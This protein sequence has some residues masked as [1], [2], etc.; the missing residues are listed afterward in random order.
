MRRGQVEFVAL[1]G[2]VLVAL[3][4]IAIAYQD[5]LPSI[6][7]A[8]LSSDEQLVH[9]SVNG[10]LADG[11]IHVVDEMERHGGYLS[12][13]QLGN[14]DGTIPAFTTYLGDGVPYWQVCDT[15]LAPSMNQ[16][17][18][19]F[20][21]ALKKYLTENMN[22]NPL[23]GK[24]VTFDL[25]K[26]SIEI[27]IFDSRVEATATIPTKIKGTTANPV[28]QAMTPTSLGRI[29]SFA[30]DVATSFANTRQFDHNTITSLYLVKDA[31]DGFSRIPV[32]GMIYECG[33]GFTRSP[34]DLGEALSDV[35]EYVL[36]NTYW[37]V[38]IPKEDDKQM[39]FDITTVNGVSY[40]DLTIQQ[41]LPDGLDFTA[42][43]PMVAYANKQLLNY[44][45]LAI[46]GLALPIC[47]S[48][49]LFAPSF[50]YPYIIEVEDE[51]TGNAFRFAGFVS[52]EEMK[53][54]S[55]DSATPLDVSAHCPD[56]LCTGTVRVRD[57][58]GTPVPGAA[59]IYG[60]CFSGMTDTNGVLTGPVAC[61]GS[62]TLH[63]YEPDHNVLSQTV[64]TAELVNGYDVTIGVNVPHTMSFR[65][66]TVATGTPYTTCTS[67]VPDGPVSVKLTA[68]ETIHSFLNTD[69]S[70]CYDNPTP[71]CAACKVAVAEN[72]DAAVTDPTCTD[73]VNSCIEYASS[74]TVPSSLHLVP[75]IGGSPLDTLVS[76]TYTVEGNFLSAESPFGLEP[77]SGFQITGAVPTTPDP[78]AV[79]LPVP[80]GT[81]T[82]SKQQATMD[83][84]NSCG[85]DT[86]RVGGPYASTIYHFNQVCTC[87]DLQA[88]ATMLQG[89]GCLTAQQVAGAFASTCSPENVKAMISSSCDAAIT[90]AC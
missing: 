28:Y 77:V 20:A 45:P 34:E 54:A 50:T 87:S 55:C 18:T 64:A 62:D 74:I 53:V 68:G 56:L 8:A 17:K 30:Q 71:T 80:G 76:G 79:S 7:P 29:I 41:R 81:T 35:V 58:E 66:V 12:L 15:N 61:T 26:L 2:I 57:N 78:L 31:D 72:G 88:I 38:D 89:T 37:F 44:P 1:V 33:T 49:F 63:V 51:F 32:G 90:G 22:I 6:G 11:I 14:E 67:V 16:I 83:L 69:L 43:A 70:G 47:H 48:S 19:D 13:E 46:L 27:T 21:F 85:M 84:K 42:S 9:N 36:A 3:V 86:F 23:P 4:V 82:A 39:V 52:V 5:Y 10:I 40:H 65:E 75:G 24:D 59:V 25:S 60:D 73:C